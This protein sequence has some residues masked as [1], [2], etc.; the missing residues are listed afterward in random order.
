MIWFGWEKQG[1]M[2]G[3]QGSG[4]GAGAVPGFA[5]G[6]GVYVGQID[7]RE[8]VK[9][10]GCCQLSKEDGFVGGGGS[11]SQVNARFAPLQYAHE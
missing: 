11:W 7:G 6:G 4:L 8:A 2:M 3:I 10:C 1:G 5:L 9:A